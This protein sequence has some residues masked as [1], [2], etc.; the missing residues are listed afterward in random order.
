MPPKR[1][2][3]GEERDPWHLGGKPEL[4]APSPPPELEAKKGSSGLPRVKREPLAVPPAGLLGVPISGEGP[5]LLRWPRGVLMT[6]IERVWGLLLWGQN[7]RLG[8]LD[9]LHGGGASH[10]VLVVC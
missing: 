5:V 1:R 9:P 8:N 4:G 7:K 10:A 3:D 2:L 6:G